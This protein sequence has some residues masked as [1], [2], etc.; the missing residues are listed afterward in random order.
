MCVCKKKATNPGLWW[1]LGYLKYKRIAKNAKLYKKGTTF[2]TWVKNEVK[3]GTYE[4]A[5]M[6]IIINFNNGFVHYYNVLL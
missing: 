2:K 5:A 4:I 1:A 3:G 6:L